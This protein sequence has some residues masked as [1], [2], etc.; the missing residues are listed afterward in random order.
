M[1]NK[2]PRQTKVLEMNADADTLL[3]EIEE[4]MDSIASA[5]D[6]LRG[7][8]RFAEWFDTL[9]ELW[10]DM[11]PM[12]EELDAQVQAEWEREQAALNREFER[13]RWNDIRR[14]M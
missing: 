1:L 8:E 3:S 11:L 5:M 2:K 6:N 7:Y 9:D 12:Q 10:D 13:D 4:A 14:N